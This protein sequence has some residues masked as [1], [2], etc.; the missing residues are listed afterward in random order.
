MEKVK[1]KRNIKKIITLVVVTIVVLIGTTTAIIGNYL[2][3]FALVNQP[4]KDVTPSAETN[5]PEDENSRIIDANKTSEDQ[6]VEQWENEV[7]IDIVDITSS[8]GLKLVADQVVNTM[9]SHDWVILVHGYQA[10]RQAMRGLASKY[11][12]QGYNIL[13][14][15]LRAHGDSEGEYIG[16]GWPDRLDL[17]QWIDHI[18]D[19]DDECSI[20]L[21]GISMGAATVMM[22]SGEVLPHNVKVIIEDCGYTSVWDIFSDELSA[23][24]GLPEFPV[25]YMADLVA[26]IRVGYEFKQASALGQVK[27]STVPMLFIHGSDDQF[28]FTEMIEPL[29]EACPTSKAKLIIDGAGHGEA[30]LR[31]PQL[32]YDTVFEFI[33]SNMA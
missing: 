24:F 18:I 3:D 26:T 29:Y 7:N 8:D 16:M 10:N 32:Y 25:L 14:P 19:M 12:E 2:V 6:L 30:R 20:V 9:D 11:Y 1:K 33:D 4:G 13:M 23:L 31:D 17:L 27:K 28:V 21:H 22:T 5:K 15:D